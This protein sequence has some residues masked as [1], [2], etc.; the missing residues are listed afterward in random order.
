MSGLDDRVK[1]AFTQI[2]TVQYLIILWLILLSVIIAVNV[3]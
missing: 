2:M 1:Q 3:F